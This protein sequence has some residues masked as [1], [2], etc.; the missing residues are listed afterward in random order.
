MSLGGDPTGSGRE[1]LGAALR[2]LSL[3]T[4]LGAA[5]VLAFELASLGRSLGPFL[6]A[7]EL[8]LPRRMALLHHSLL[9]AAT[10]ALGAIALLAAVWRRRRGVETAERWSWWVS[11]ALLLPALPIVTTSLAWRGKHENL[12]VITVALLLLVEV[13]VFRSA[14]AVPS[15]VRTAWRGAVHH[16][17]RFLQ[18]QGPL[19]FVLAGAVFYSVFM[20]YYTVQ[21]HHKLETGNYDLSINNN[22]IYGALHG[23]FLHSP[24]TMPDDPGAYGAIHVK[25]G[26]YVLLPFYA[27]FPRAESLFVIQATLLG[28]GALPL[29]GFARRHVS[30]WMAALI[31]G[32]YLLYYPMHGVTFTDCNYI[33]TAT[34]FVL[35][36]VWALEERRWIWFGLAFLAA[37]L[38][39]EDIPIGLAVVGAFFAASGRRPRMGLLMAVVATG[40]FVYLRFFWMDEKGEWWFPSMYKGLWSP[41]EEGFKSVIKTLLTNQAFVLHRLVEKDRL[42]YLLHLFVPLAFLP[43]RRWYLWAAFLPGVVLTLLATDYKPPTMFSFQYVMHWTPYLFLAAPLALASIAARADAGPVRARAAAAAMLFASLALQY[44]YGAF[45]ARDGSVKGGYKIIEFSFHEDE[46]Q[47][48]A[49]LLEVIRQ[50]PPEASVAATENVG[51]HVSSRVTIYAARY[52]PHG[53]DY[54]LASQRELGLKQ[55]R[56]KLK[57]ALE[58]GRYG[59]LFRKADF[60]LMKR[61]HETTGNEGL[62]A[63]WFGKRVPVEDV[64]E[65]AAPEDDD[66]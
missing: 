43:A 13:L 29:Y 55:T 58:S 65:S 22:L 8:P 32:C 53:A 38:M 50:I 54:Y 52:G 3:A 31:A 7:N 42:Y 16:T 66:R 37:C 12:L 36:T 20:S 2:V 30:S 18:R 25:L 33:P 34:F 24:V 23:K 21:W 60:A 63:D 56:P 64:D 59:V 45:P 11:P 48:Y 28:M 41:G 40:W 46:R 5:V 47:R 10:G 62:L 4:C 1:R 6:S 49:D 27:L 57:E 35:A 44:N 9:G 39:R 51:P 14:M 26:T 15:V 19:L 61:G 17:P